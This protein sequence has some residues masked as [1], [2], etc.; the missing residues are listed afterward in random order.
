MLFRSRH[1]TV[2]RRDIVRRA[3]ALCAGI[4]GLLGGA[5]PGRAAGNTLIM[6]YDPG[7]TC[8]MGQYAALLKGFFTQEGLSVQ[9]VRTLDNRTAV[10][11]GRSHRLWVKTEAGLTEADFGYFDTDQLHHMVAG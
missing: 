1:D 6:G 8:H 4:A 5:K 11:Q 3:A 9:G 2:S 7:L 10:T